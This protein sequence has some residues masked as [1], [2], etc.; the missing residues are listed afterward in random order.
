MSKSK[1]RKFRW[2][3]NWGQ[4]GSG[5]AMFLGGGSVALA[6]YAGGY[7][8]FWPIGIA[9]VGFV[10]MLLGLLGEDGVW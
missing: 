2:G 10:I 5:G 6:A 1:K 7:I 4:V 9:A 8:W 3:F